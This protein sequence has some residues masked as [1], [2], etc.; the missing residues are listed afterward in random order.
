MKIKGKGENSS[1]LWLGTL[2]QPKWLPM[3]ITGQVVPLL[4][5]FH[6]I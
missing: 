3:L 1:M 5:L 2:V 4:V 6:Q